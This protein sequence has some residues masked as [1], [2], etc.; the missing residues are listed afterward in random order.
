MSGI[1]N[2]ENDLSASIEASASDEGRA[3]SAELLEAFMALMPDAAVVIDE[4]GHIVAVNEQ[5]EDLFS[6]SRGELA[7]LTIEALIPERV[8]HRHREHRSRYL[9]EPA[10]RPMGGGLELTGR[11]R[12]GHEF[13]VDI[14]LAPIVSSG[15]RLV[16][17]AVRDETDRQETIAAQAELATIVRSSLDAIISTTL[18][19]HITNWNPAAE[20]LFGY[21]RD[22][23]LGEH[24]AM[25]APD[26]ESIVL[27]ELL[28]HTYQG[29]HRSSRDTKWRHRQGH[30]VDVAVSIS[31]MKDQGGALLGFS[32]VVRDITEQKFAEVEMRR[33]LTEEENQRRQQTATAE[34]RLALL[35]GLSLHD[36]WM[37]I[38]ERAAELVGAPVA[39][40]SVRE[41]NRIHIAA[42]VGPA[43][44]MIGTSLPIG[45]SFVEQVL[46]AGQ[47]IEIERRSDRSRVEVPG[48]MP[49]GPT[50][51][52]PV[53]IDDEARATLTFVREQG[54]SGFSQ[55][56]CLFAEALAAQAA[57]AY[58]FERSRQDQEQL[59]LVGDRER[60]A[61]DLHDLVIHRLFAAGIRLQDTAPLIGDPVARDRISETIDSIDETIREIRNAIFSLSLSATA[62]HRL[63]SQIIELAHGASNVLGFD[64]TVRFEGPV[65]TVV[66]DPVVPHLLAAV[67]EALSNV[68]R[69]A[70]ASAVSL[71]VSAEGHEIRLEVFDDGVGITDL[72]QSSGLSNLKERAALLGGSFGATNREEGGTRLIWRVPIVKSN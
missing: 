11:R 71:Y 27:E 25:L 41:E 6:Y 23:V 72:T 1:G 38:C 46:E 48:A 68:A 4:R 33:L 51:G 34:I 66:P 29:S 39:V 47:L 57:I 32:A 62:E 2:S 9:T 15:Q 54:S 70:H 58:T 53:I 40:I 63:R 60:I 24:I 12:D 26:Q 42:A 50:L 5:A 56:D 69:H 61:R 3:I 18:E 49:D 16:V 19:G 64:P 37:L 59:M 10:A 55:A 8:R 45:I 31:P 44:E 52:V 43:S 14:S 13:P 21:S 22:Q 36:S 7:G 67:R 65:D 35:S 30:E 28:D 17:A 20:H